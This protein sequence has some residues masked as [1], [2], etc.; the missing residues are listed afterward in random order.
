MNAIHLF[1]LD[2]HLT[3]VHARIDAL[4]F[5]PVFFFSMRYDRSNDAKDRQQHISIVSCVF[6]TV[7]TWSSFHSDQ[8]I[9]FLELSCTF[10]D[11]IGRQKKSTLSSLKKVNFEFPWISRIR[12]GFSNLFGPEF[13]L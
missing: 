8:E 2:I 3:V 5:G 13:S 1:E 9:Q 10:V 6:R 7:Y 11:Q 4:S 12:V